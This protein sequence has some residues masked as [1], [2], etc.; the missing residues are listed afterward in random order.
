MVGIQRRIVRQKQVAFFL[1]AR[2]FACI[3][4]TSKN[5]SSTKLLSFVPPLMSREAVMR[6]IALAD[7]M[8]LPSGDAARREHVV[9]SDIFP[10]Y[11]MLVCAVGVLGARGTGCGYSFHGWVPSSCGLRDDSYPEEK[12][13][14]A[15]NTAP[16]SPQA[17][18]ENTVCSQNTHNMWDSG[19]AWR[20]TT[21]KAAKY[22][23]G[24]EDS[25]L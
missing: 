25:A 23:D 22:L 17:I 1:F 15:P 2:L 8:Y 7:V 21:Q 20:L 13:D 4:P 14:A 9:H 18:V 5:M 3:V 24:S 12:T 10:N 11:R 6:T 19:H 16:E